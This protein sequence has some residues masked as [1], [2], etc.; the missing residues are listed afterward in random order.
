MQSPSSTMVKN[1]RSASR[2]LVRELGFMNRTLAGTELS[3]S[4]VHAII[5][6]GANGH[7][8]SKALSESLLLE[9][10][11]ISR[12]VRSLVDRGEVH[13]I[14]SH[15]DARSKDLHLTNKGEAT[16]AKIANYAGQ[17][18]AVAIDPLDGHARRQILTSLK[19]YSAALRAGRTSGAVPVVGGQVDIRHGYTPGI[20]ARIT[21]LHASY[22]S[23]L[24]GFGVA[25]EAKVAGG[26]ADFAPR[27]DK[28]QNAL[29]YAQDNN[30]IVGSIGID[31]E[32]LGAGKAHLRW[33]ILDQ[34]IQGTGVGKSL[35]QKAV[36]FCDDRKFRETDLWTFK[37]LDAARAL[38]ERHGFELTEEYRGDQWGTPML[39]QKFTRRRPT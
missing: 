9:K 24:V 36:T 12:L 17:Q 39:E 30:R 26:L 21:E 18:V 35:I 14:R 13:E 25:F 4:A 3:A 37:G 23:N 1:I 31:G 34:R 20:I 5:E 7:L 6:I 32:D 15:E 11:T 8:S 29:W 2:D 33:F 28:P 22:Y 19:T 27:L 16:L 38:Y 10:S